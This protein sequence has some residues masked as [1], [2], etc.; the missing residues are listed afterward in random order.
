[1]SMINLARCLSTRISG[2]HSTRPEHDEIVPQPSP[3]IQEVLAL[4][5]LQRFLESDDANDE[6][7]R[8]ED[9]GDEEPKYAPKL[10]WAA[11]EA[12]EG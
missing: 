8:K 10:W 6:P 5:L 4:L 3:G 11:H 9:D 2:A 12:R 7:R 1:M